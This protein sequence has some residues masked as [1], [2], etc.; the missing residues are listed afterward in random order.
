ML[1]CIYNCKCNVKSCVVMCQW[2]L[3][4]IFVCFHLG[5][6]EKGWGKEKGG[7]KEKGWK[8]NIDIVLLFYSLVKQKAHIFYFCTVYI[9]TTQLRFY[10]LSC[11]SG[12]N[13]LLW[14]LILWT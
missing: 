14:V 11:F 13:R 1:N 8:G 6:E 2:C 10:I 9:S 3:S 7:R 4:I 5:K 12:Q